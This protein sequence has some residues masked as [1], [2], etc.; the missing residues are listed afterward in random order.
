MG[1]PL[2]LIRWDAASG[3]F[4]VGDRAADA[5][6]RLAGPVSVVAVCGRAR[7]GKSFI[8]NQLLQV[9]GGF[10]IGS[11]HRPCTKGL[12]M[13]SAPQ[14]RVD[15]AGREYHVV[16]LDTEG[17]DAYDQTAQYSTQVFSLAVLL[18]SL[19]VFNQ[20]ALVTEMTR[21]VRVRASGGGGCG[22]GGG[23]GPDADAAELGAHTPAFL[24][25]LRDFYLRLE[26]EAG[27]AVTP[28]AYLEAALAPAP[29]GGPAAD[30]KNAALV[31]LDTTPPEALRPEFR[32]GVAALIKLIFE[33][34]QPK[35]LGALELTGPLLAGLAEAYVTAINDGAVPTITTAWQARRRGAAQQQAPRRPRAA[36]PAVG[37]GRARAR[38]RP[39]AAQGVAEQE[40]RRAADAAEAA[41][42]R[43]FSE[44]TPA[45]GRT[46]AASGAPR[47]PCAAP[48]A[49]RPAAR[50]T[51]AAPRG[52]GGQ[53]VPPEDAELAAEHARCLGAA[54]AAFDAV[55]VGEPA[56][57]AAHRRRY[58]DACAARFAQ[59]RGRR[60]A[61]AAAAA[62]ELLLAGAARLSAA[63]SSGAPA[64]ALPDALARA[65]RDALARQE[66]QARSDV[67][68]LAE[69]LGAA[70]RQAAALRERADKAEASAGAA[71]GEADGL[72]RRLKEASHEL[73]GLR[74]ESEARAAK[75]GAAG[76]GPPRQPVCGEGGQR[77]VARFLS[78]RLPPRPP[79]VGAGGAAAGAA[80][81]GEKRLLGARQEADAAARAARLAHQQE[82]T[83]LQAQ[84][85]AESARAG[86]LAAEVAELSAQ[87][88]GLGGQL[89][90]AHGAEADLCERL[91]ASKADAA[92]LARQLDEARAQLAA[93]ALQRQLAERARDEA[94]AAVAELEEQ[95]EDIGV[96]IAGHMQEAEA[97]QE[98]AHS[99]TGAGAARLGGS[100]KASG[101][102]LLLPALS[103]EL[104]QQDGAQLIKAG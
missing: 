47:R 27:G 54:G 34:A 23:G 55:A 38:R 17:I 69:A 79:G 1:E 100:R 75:V 13:W 103:G 71:G 9:T 18:S 77:A 35:R 43:E 90:A 52:A 44:V 28:S 67:L 56:I 95:L 102:G 8:L 33:K 46:R 12:W 94:Q 91:A 24:W 59:V 3:K 49:A 15:A 104:Q 97:E 81:P 16:L 25:L 72:R 68:R 48:H 21:H 4:A 7:Q 11:T 39:R 14:R 26:D 58:A 85:A 63:A 30:A 37:D 10:Q 22:P 65:V 89:A 36:R 93:A 76:G 99:L 45:R 82:A 73:A 83:A 96:Q 66:T 84:A 40:C 31:S 78:A 92:G 61:E 53:D 2:E 70:Q 42:A 19:F 60:L 20:L 50:A 41:Y 6:R 98:R 86:G 5:L 64:D 80:A 101:G 29:G 74:V 87:L 57:V 32:E 88:A 51:P 62:N